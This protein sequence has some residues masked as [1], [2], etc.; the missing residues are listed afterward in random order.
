MATSATIFRDDHIFHTLAESRAQNVLDHLDAELRTSVRLIGLRFRLSGSTPARAEVVVVPPESEIVPDDFA[1]LDTRVREVQARDSETGSRP[2]SPPMELLRRAACA[3]LTVVDS[4]DGRRS[5][6]G[7]PV[8]LPGGDPDVEIVILPVIRVDAGAFGVLP[9]LTRY[10]FELSA[11]SQ[12]RIATSLVDAAVLELFAFVE[13]GL[14]HPRPIHQEAGRLRPEEV[15]H[16]AAVRLM[17]TPEAAVDVLALEQLSEACDRIAV[18]KYEGGEARGRLVIAPHDHPALETLLTLDP[19]VPVSNH[20]AVRK[21]LEMSSRDGPGLVTNGT[22]IMGLA[23]IGRGYDQGTEVCFTVDFWGNGAW[24]LRHAEKPLMVV[25]YGRPELPRPPV[26]RDSIRDRLRVLDP[27]ATEEAEAWLWDAIEAAVDAG[28]GAL[29][30]ISRAAPAEAARLRPQALPITPIP[31]TSDLATRTT[32]IDGALL[33][34]TDGRCYAIGAILDGRAGGAGQASRGS[35]YNSAVR[36]VNTQAGAC[37]AVVVS[38]D[39]M[40]DLVSR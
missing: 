5:F 21:L 39:G 20:R 31:L 33:I 25:R 37:F 34:G 15:L 14:L 27:S 38:E 32:A 29:L 28:H 22:D 18:M 7:T 30:V 9:A 13:D 11:V 36:Y 16:R 17:H 12:A 2:Q 8:V 26:A 6:A 4:R 24:E 3:V 1:D 10:A 19:P 40:V 23:M 35:R